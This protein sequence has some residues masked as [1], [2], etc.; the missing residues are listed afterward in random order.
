MYFGIAVGTDEME[1]SDIGMCR[2]AFTNRATDAF[3]CNDTNV[4]E[5]Y[6]I[7]NDTSNDLY[8]YTTVSPLSYVRTATT[9]ATTNFIAKFTRPMQTNDTTYDRQLSNETYDM[10]WS[11]GYIVNNT[12]VEHTAENHGVAKLN[13]T[14]APYYPTASAAKMLTAFVGLAAATLFLY[15]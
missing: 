2:Y 6:Q 11:F 10:L 1:H 9:A 13:L 3:V 15:F 4:D 12:L 7:W 14:M 5:N 8:N